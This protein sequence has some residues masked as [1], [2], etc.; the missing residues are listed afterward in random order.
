[1]N[2]KGYKIEKLHTM[3]RKVWTIECSDFIK[4]F[5]LSRACPEVGLNV[6]FEGTT[7]KY[8]LTRTLADAKSYVDECI[9]DHE[10]YIDSYFSGR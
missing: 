10:L 3:G 6:Q 5:L 2:Y 1:M 9:I 4:T 8:I 7:P